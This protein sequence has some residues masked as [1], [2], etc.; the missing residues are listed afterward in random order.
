MRTKIVFLLLFIVTYS[1]TSAQ[2]PGLIGDNTIDYGN[3][4]EYVIENI[5]VTGAVHF[6]EKAIILL[7]ELERGQKIKIPGDEISKAIK[8]L[9]D[10]KLFSEVAIDAT[11]IRGDKIFLDIR[12]KERPRL[13]G[14][15]PR[16][17][18]K[19]EWEKAKENLDLYVGRIVTDNLI[20][21]TKTHVKN[22]FIEK[23]YLNTTVE[24]S[25]A[26]DTS[27]FNNAVLLIIKVNKGAKVKIKDIEIEGNESLSDG[28]ILRLLKDTKR[29]NWVRFWKTSKYLES[30]LRNEKVAIITKLNDKGLRDARIVYDSVY[31]VDE[32]HVS[33]KLKVEEGKKYYFRNITWIGNSKYT[34]GKLDTLLGIKKGDVYNQSALESRLFMSA[35]GTDISSLYMDNGYLFFSV[36]PVEVR[37][38]NDSIDFEMRV[39]EGKQ[40]RIR[41]IS[42]KGNTKTNDHVIRREIRTKPGELFSRN[43]I[44]RTQRELSQLG[45]FDP[46]KFG[47]NPV[48]NPYDGTV[49]IEYSVEERPSDQVELSGGW[50]AGRVIGTL[51]LSFNN[52]SIRKVFKKGAWQPL[53]AGDGQQLS[54][55]A[56]STGT[57]YQGYNFS[58]TEPWLGGKKPN[59]LSVNMYHTFS[60]RDNLRRD[61]PAKSRLKITGASIGFGKRLKWPD[62]YFNIYVEV[63]SYQYYDLQ[64]YNGV[65]TF[66]QG[67][68]N[69]LATRFSITRNSVNQPLYPSSGSTITISGKF[70]PP[71]SYFNNKDYST[72]SDQERYKWLEFNKWKF[73]T[74]HFLS[75]NK[76]K[77]HKLVLNA[78]TGFG[79]LL[80]WNR[81]VGDS[82]FERFKLGGSGL[83]G[84]NFIFGQEIIALRGYNDQAVSKSVGD[85]FIAKYTLELRFPLSLN[86][87]ATVY[88]LGFAEGGNTWQKIK[89]FDPFDVKRAAG[90]GV[91]IFLPMFGLLGLDYGW[92]FDKV[93]NDPTFKPGSGQFFFT[94]GMNLGE[95]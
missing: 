38:E 12:V 34:S 91:R 79:F 74:S 62:D 88:M 83:S 39:I 16:G 89:N 25:Q 3:P 49:D 20:A 92:G 52:F 82:P 77:K 22:F 90:V 9:W 8:K 75:L 61:D 43:D 50:G 76:N 24:I 44:I 84:M 56:Q 65:F 80:P 95:L 31:K 7:S 51:G 85:L 30:N 60:S 81:A 28:K 27:K 21:N 17:I 29:E 87:N 53:P 66:S 48:P 10:Q 64:N 11:Q 70:T 2:A 54:I 57:F 26:T 33:I 72:L 73:T 41:S 86:P 36:T 15:S 93:E 19:G 78:R 69:N 1:L 5:T 59:S 47:V 63:P 13:A 46:E 14:Y 23:G 94:I 18:K 68:V 32:S 40:A 67:Y 37:V 71:Y 58:F 55:R 45:Y 35:N 6:D 42:I 4:K